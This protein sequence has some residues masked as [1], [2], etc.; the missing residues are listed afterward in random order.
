MRN[1]ICVS[2]KLAVESSRANSRS[3]TAILL[4]NLI[5]KL[6]NKFVKK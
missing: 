6:Y 2:F 4:L 1:G 3:I 5:A